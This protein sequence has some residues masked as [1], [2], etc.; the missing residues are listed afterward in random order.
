MNKSELVSNSESPSDSEKPM[1]KFPTSNVV[2]DVV[3]W[4]PAAAREELLARLPPMSLRQAMNESSAF[5]MNF[6]RM[7]YFAK[8]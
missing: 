7:R 5:H 1:S 2:V 3:D 4:L 6:M 8:Y